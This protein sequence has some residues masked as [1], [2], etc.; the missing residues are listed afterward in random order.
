MTKSILKRIKT[1]FETRKREVDVDSIK[2]YDK[3]NKEH[4]PD[5]IKMIADSIMKFWFTAPMVIDSNWVLIVWHWRFVAAKSLWIKTLPAL[6]IDD[7]TEEWDT[8][9]DGE[10]VYIIKPSADDCILLEQYL[11]ENSI[12]YTKKW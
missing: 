3:N 2:E 1:Q 8:N 7:L 4:W 10:S 12:S 11:D 6:I 5:Q 9:I